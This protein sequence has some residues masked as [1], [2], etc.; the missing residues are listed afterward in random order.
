[1]AG[2]FSCQKKR[3]LTQ[4]SFARSHL[5]RL[6]SD[7]LP[8]KLTF[9]ERKIKQ[10]VLRQVLRVS[11]TCANA[12]LLGRAIVTKLSP[13]SALRWHQKIH[14]EWTSAIEMIEPPALG[15]L[16]KNPRP[17]IQ[18]AQA[19]ERR[20]ISNGSILSCAM[21]QPSGDF[22]GTVISSFQFYWH[23]WICL[24]VFG[25]VTCIGILCIDFGCLVWYPYLC[26][27]FRRLKQGYK[28]QVDWPDS[29]KIRSLQLK[30]CPT[31]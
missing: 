1:M 28:Y 6:F 21:L 10:S 8:F 30:I 2:R 19:R 7:S 4:C 24:W 25:L 22:W 23:D 31:R 27:I 26:N 17:G 14:Q 15:H 11:Q 3:V 20:W 16:C 5:Q 13:V 29:S 12:Q 18:P 9:C